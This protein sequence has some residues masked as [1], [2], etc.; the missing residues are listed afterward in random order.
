MTKKGEAKRLVKIRCQGSGTA[1][2]GEVQPFQGNLKTLHKDDY[3]K[4]RGLIEAQGF[5]FPLFVWRGEDKTLYLLD[6]HQRRSTLLKMQEE[7][8][9]IPP[10]PYDEVYASTFKEAKEKLLAAA[11][12]FAKV[13]RQ[14][15]YEFMGEADIDLSFLQSNI[16]LPS[17][18][19]ESFETEF[20]REHEGKPVGDPSKE[21]NGMPEFNQEDKTSYRHI[22]VH[23]QN[24]EDVRK[25]GELIGQSMTNKTRSIWF[26]KVENESMMDKRYASES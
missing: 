10:I 7:G 15:L 26:P 13:D 16:V 4:L 5:S 9:E 8:W 1:R 3:L 24:D 12:Q 20:Y 18:N 22:V 19:V 14:G 2:I 6:G 21:W 25:F 17:L 23:F 11:S